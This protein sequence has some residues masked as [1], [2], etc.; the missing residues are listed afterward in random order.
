MTKTI[1]SYRLH[2][3][4]GQAVVRLD[5]RDYYLGKHSTDPSHEKYRRLVAKWLSG[6]GA[7]GAMRSWPPANDGPCPDAHDR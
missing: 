3:P 2:R 7:R 4:T 1:P 6:L 5:G